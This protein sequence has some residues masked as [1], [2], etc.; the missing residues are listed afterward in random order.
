MEITQPEQQTEIQKKK[1]KQYKGLWNNIKYDNL[2]IIGIAEGE[3]RERGI[4]NVFEE[5]MAVNIAN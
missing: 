2:P 3:E 1:R 4:E 5:S